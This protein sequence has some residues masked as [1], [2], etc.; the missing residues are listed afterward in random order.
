MTSLPAI[1]E[2]I[3]THA[4]IAGCGVAEEEPD[5]MQISDDEITDRVEDDRTFRIA[6]PLERRVKTQ[7]EDCDVIT[8][9]D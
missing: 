2:A 6:E 9:V 8:F 7:I 4:L 1:D 3:K 5:D